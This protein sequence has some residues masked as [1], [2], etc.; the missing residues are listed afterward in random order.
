VVPSNS[1]SPEDQS[2]RQMESHFEIVEGLLS[3]HRFLLSETPSL[4]D[5]ATFGAIYPLYYAGD[6][7]PANFVKLLAWYSSIDRI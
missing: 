6:W 4:A 5:F 1:S 2:S 7:I 3:K